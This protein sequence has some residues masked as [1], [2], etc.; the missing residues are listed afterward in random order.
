MTYR[1]VFKE[2]ALKEWRRLG[3]TV[4]EQFKKK[5][6]ERLENPMVPGDRLSG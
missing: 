3:D 4:R 1:L 5:L 2:E 6:A